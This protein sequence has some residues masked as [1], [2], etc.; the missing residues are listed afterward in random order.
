MLHYGIYTLAS[1][2]KRVIIHGIIRCRISD[3]I[4][5]L[6]RFPNSNINFI[7]NMQ[8]LTVDG[9]NND[10]YVNSWYYNWYNNRNMFLL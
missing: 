2:Q 7:K 6:C 4:S 1:S 5:Y 10:W 3:K 9:Q 8:D